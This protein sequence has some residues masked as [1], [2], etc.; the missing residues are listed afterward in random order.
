MSTFYEFDVRILKAAA[1][2]YFMTAEVEGTNPTAPE[3]LD[4]RALSQ[5][6]FV[7]SL[8]QMREEEFSLKEAV[9][10]GVGTTLYEALF[11]GQVKA[12]FEAVYSRDVEPKPETYLRVR[13]A[14]DERA[15][16]IAELPWE[17][18]FWRGGFLATHSRILLTRQLLNVDYGSIKSLNIEGKPR[19]LV[20]IPRGSGLDTDG[21]ENA[22]KGVFD[23]AAIPYEVLKGRV[24]VQSLID[25]LRR[26]GPAPFNILHF[27]G[28]GDFER[29][30][31]IQPRAILRFNHPDLPDDSDEKD[32]EVWID[33]TQIRQVIEPHRDQL[34]L[35]VLNA[36]KGGE[37]AGPEQKRRARA[38]GPGFVGMVPAI[39]MAGAPA[40]IAM[41]YEIRD[42][43]AKR[44]GK[45]FY[46][47]LTAGAAAGRVD[48]AMSLARSDC[49]VN[50]KDSDWRG[51]GT[52]V[53]YLH[54]VDGSIFV[55][56]SVDDSAAA[57]ATRVSP[58]P[59]SCPEPEKPDDSLI[60]DHRYDSTSTMLSTVNS[61]R[62]VLAG[63]QRQIDYLEKTA[64]D[65]PL[66]A[67]AG[68]LGPQIDRLK[69]QKK[70]KERELEDNKLVLCWKLYEDCVKRETLRQEIAQLEAERDGLQAQ[71]KH[72]TYELKNRI[73]EA[74][75]E[76]R[77]LDD[78]LKQGEDQCK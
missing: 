72:V 54:A 77:D 3:V 11:Q 28:H 78:V 75:G 63:I 56:K 68:M 55:V 58:P 69:E 6:E 31:G 42:D 45:S 5:D 36:C 71:G 27:I 44:F 74:R 48:A 39:L 37:V 1:G 59:A 76:A 2:H 33:Q 40:V 15:P 49:F 70:A 64:A 50:F 14:I 60:H 30:E 20:V 18:L 4:W 47:T 10:T 38:S 9:V 73:S 19:V 13:I 25:K 65:N 51:F 21:E 26:P 23:E 35:V 22:I 67:A 62:E 17:F 24:F 43:V 8:R 12:L 16:E 66:L 41:Q 53:L 52:P 57:S 34:R 46:E 32:D 7:E 61:Q 29:E